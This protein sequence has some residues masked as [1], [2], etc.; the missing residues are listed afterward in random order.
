[1]CRIF[2]RNERSREKRQT[3]FERQSCLQEHAIDRDAGAAAATPSTTPPARTRRPAGGQHANFIA[4]PPRRTFFSITF[5]PGDA[6]PVSD[7]LRMTTP[8]ISHL[9]GTK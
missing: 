2:V 9:L 1:V 6:T 4:C 5:S 8:Q 3:R 7:P